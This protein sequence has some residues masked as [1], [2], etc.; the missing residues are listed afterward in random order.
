MS[1]KQMA[2]S[3]AIN[4]RFNNGLYV[5]QLAV[6][7]LNPGIAIETLKNI[8]DRLEH[9][10]RNHDNVYS[11]HDPPKPTACRSARRSARSA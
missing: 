6:N 2:D 5:R 1:M 7:N 11:I 10:L 9:N 3:L 8:F 4:L